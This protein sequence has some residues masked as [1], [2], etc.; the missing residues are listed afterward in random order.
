MHNFKNVR[1]K[2]KSFKKNLTLIFGIPPV[3]N[4][5]QIDKTHPVDIIIHHEL[6]SVRYVRF[7]GL[8]FL[9]QNRPALEKKNINR[10]LSGKVAVNYFPE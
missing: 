6:Q 3:F 10:K 8:K 7:V 2:V 5:C 9:S 4:F 1:F